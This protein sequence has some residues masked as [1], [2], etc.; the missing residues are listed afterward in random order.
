MAKCAAGQVSP[1]PAHGVTMEKDHPN[2]QPVHT[3]LRGSHSEDSQILLILQNLSSLNCF[4]HAEGRKFVNLTTDFL[5]ILP[6]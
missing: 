6:E 2:T 5:K 1:Q 4:I 3:Q